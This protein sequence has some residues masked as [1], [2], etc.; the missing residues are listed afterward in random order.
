MASRKSPTLV[1]PEPELLTYL[2]LVFAE[3]RLR[4]IFVEVNHN[5][6][7]VMG[8]YRDKRLH[9]A[10]PLQPDQRDKLAALV[11]R[12][13]W[14]LNAVDEA[15]MRLGRQ[16]PYNLP[17]LNRSGTIAMRPYLHKRI[18]LLPYRWKSSARKPHVEP[19]D[20]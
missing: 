12:Y 16:W 15:G 10:L 4:R 2:A 1:T 17:F 20:P 5:R 11:L 3:R 13:W 6:P 19:Q 18:A 9:H 7:S 8:V 14:Q